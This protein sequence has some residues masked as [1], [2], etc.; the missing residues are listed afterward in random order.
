[1]FGMTLEPG[2]AE[3]RA[4]T[5]LAACIEGGLDVLVL[6]A[7]G[8]PRHHPE[9]AAGKVD[10]VVH[11]EPSGRSF[12]ILRVVEVLGVENDVVQLQELFRHEAGEL[13]ATGLRPEL[14]DRLHDQG[15]TLDPLTFALQRRS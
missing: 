11:Q 6:P 5:F 12:R 8:S 14:L 3:R 1:M 7:G 4:T 13:R 2:P 9:V 10:I 15:I